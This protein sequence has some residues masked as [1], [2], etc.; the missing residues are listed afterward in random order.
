MTT[1]SAPALEAALDAELEQV[2]ALDRV[3][4]AAQAE[5]YRRIESARSLAATV[6]GL[7]D[8][9]SASA[10]EFA[11]RSFVAELATALV[12]H[13]ATASRLVAEVG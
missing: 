10:R 2:A 5:Q 9:S 12:V 1:R 6:E 4:R 13:E 7:A 8:S 11:T 3:I